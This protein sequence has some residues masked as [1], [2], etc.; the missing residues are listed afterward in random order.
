MNFENFVLGILDSSANFN[1]NAAIRGFLISLAVIWL[2]VVV[3]VW[4]DSGERSRNIFFRI[5]SVIL[6]LFLNMLGLIIYLLMRPKDTV[7]NLYWSDLERRFL[8]YETSE[9]GDCEN[10]GLQLRPGFNVC[11]EC[12]YPVNVECP[13]CKQLIDKHW[14]YCPYCSTKQEHQFVG[15]YP[16]SVHGVSEEALLA[17][18]MVNTDIS[19]AMRNNPGPVEEDLTKTRTAQVE[20]QPTLQ[21]SKLGE[22]E[23]VEKEPVKKA[24]PEVSDEVEETNIPEP[25]EEVQEELAKEEEKPKSAPVPSKEEMA[26]SV[27]GTKEKMND[28]LKEKG[29]KYQQSPGVAVRLG[30]YVMVSVYKFGEKINKAAL[31]VSGRI[32]T[33]SNKAAVE[34]NQSSGVKGEEKSE[35]PEKKEATDKKKDPKSNKAKGSNSKKKNSKK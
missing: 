19:R 14:N 12:S 20:V 4:M 2:F 21:E 25:E 3:W 5:L 1:F 18:G 8:L 28:D 34:Q 11:P 10:C 15:H 27:E 7:E 16:E 23:Q 31:K 17:A 30:N 29:M 9:L 35:Q 6:V 33:P 22:K 24:E 13:T 26:D 32:E